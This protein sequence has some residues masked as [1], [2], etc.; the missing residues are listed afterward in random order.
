M[1]KKVGATVLLLR[2]R[3]NV[4]AFCLTRGLRLSTFVRA[5]CNPEDRDAAMQ[6]VR[7]I[8]ESCCPA[9]LLYDGFSVFLNIFRCPEDGSFPSV[10]LV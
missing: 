10:C 9:S 6:G 7:G 1:I 5:A 4:N 3:L 2:H 8:Y